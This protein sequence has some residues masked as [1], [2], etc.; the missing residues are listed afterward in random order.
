MTIWQAF[1]GWVTERKPAAA[2]VNRWRCVFENLN[3]FHEDRDVVLFSE[4]DAVAWK[5]SLVTG[6]GG[7]E[8]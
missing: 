4:D 7:H 1:E 5:N 8:R 3:A 6:A 2:T